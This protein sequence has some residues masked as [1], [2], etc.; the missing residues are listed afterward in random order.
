MYASICSSELE[1]KQGHN[2]V[3]FRVLP[4][5]PGGRAAFYLFRN[6]KKE[7][8]K[9]YTQ[10]S[11]VEFEL[12]QDGLYY[13][14]A[15]IKYKE[16]QQPIIIHS[17]PVQVLHTA[18]PAR[19][20]SKATVSIFGSCVS[21]DLFSLGQAND[22]ELRCYIARQSIVSAV[23]LPVTKSLE[24]IQGVS[25]FEWRQVLN[26][27]RKSAFSQLR[28]KPADYLL[29]DLVDERFPLVKYED[30]LVTMSNGFRNSRLY[31]PS[32]PVLKKQRLELENGEIEYNVDGRSLR[33][34]VQ[35]FCE[36]ILSIFS[37]KQI[38]LH[39]VR[40]TNYYQNKD[41]EICEFEPNVKS[42]NCSINLQLD[43]LYKCFQ[44]FWPQSYM[45]DLSTGYYAVENHKW[46]LAAIHFQ[47]EYYLAV[48]GALCDIV[49][50]RYNTEH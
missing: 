20:Q 11:E 23:S 35:R 12:F 29:I 42:F 15:F 50:L 32:L 1:Q 18:I 31:V 46:G 14:A 22:F 24:P 3:R 48:L 9:W 16:E 13:A 19:L 49:N 40:F 28:D 36:E 25:A 17:K 38:I 4:P 43:Y 27:L 8:I 39:R 33:E 44:E 47:K 26:D 10:A 7:Q 5:P 30:S 41:G 34:Y 2:F 21:R 37:Q 6:G 45:I